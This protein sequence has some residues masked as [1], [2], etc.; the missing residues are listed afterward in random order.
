MYASLTADI[1]PLAS[2]GLALLLVAAAGGIVM[3][4]RYHLKQV[5][6][7][8]WLVFMHALLA[9]DGF[10]MLLIVGVRS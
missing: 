1:P 9:V 2:R 5:E 7:P 10:L 4:L 6:L 8:T 3:N